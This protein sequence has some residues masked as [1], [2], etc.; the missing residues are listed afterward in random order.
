M[1]VSAS[2]YAHYDEMSNRYRTLRY[3]MKQQ[4][5]YREEAMFWE[6]EMRARERSL[7]IHRPENW[8]LLI[9]SALYRC[10][11]RYG[12][13]ISRP[14]AFWLVLSLGCAVSYYMIDGHGALNWDPIR[15]LRSYDFSLQQTVRPFNVWSKEGEAAVKQLVFGQPVEI[16]VPK[17]V[18]VFL[19]QLGATL[20]T[21]A[22]LATIALFGFAVRR[23]FRMI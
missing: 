14:I 8:F 22:S 15:A 17:A 23:R 4:D 13:S 7:P 1:F 5:A 6:L 3:L 20:Q 9:I 10:A 2:L 11:A 12:N 21:V 19:L 18:S 16:S